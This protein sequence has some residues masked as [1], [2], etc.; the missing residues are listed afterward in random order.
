M[1][2]TLART[3]S[4]QHSVMMVERDEKRYERV[5]ENLD[6]GAVNANGANPRVL[7][8]LMNEQTELF[9]AVT[10]SDEFN[11]FACL[12][13]KQVKSDV[14]TIA[15]VRNPDYQGGVLRSSTM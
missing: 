8:D 2:T 7:K 13:A 9:L 1:G 10:E 6:I 3:L 11:M 15:R 4:K 14:V 12:V 5:I